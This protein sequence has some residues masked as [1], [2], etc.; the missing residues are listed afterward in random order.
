LEDLEG[1]DPKTVQM[2]TRHEE[3]IKRIDGWNKRQNGHLGSLDS[4]MDGLREKME[5][6]K[7]YVNEKIEEM[8]KNNNEMMNKILLA[9][10]A[11]TLSTIGGFIF[12]V[13]NS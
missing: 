8:R 6:L 11:F 9:I 13:V 2:L 12:L 4:K 10:L 1:I 7:E 5:E 3:A